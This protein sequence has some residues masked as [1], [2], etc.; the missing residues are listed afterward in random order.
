MLE[1][2]GKNADDM[3]EDIGH[4]SEARTKM[5]EYLVGTLKPDPN[6]VS[7]AKKA[8]KVAAEI[9]SGGGLNPFAIVILLIAIA[10]GYYFSQIHGK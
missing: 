8:K 4:S 2:A 5:K 9:K 10:A 1:F 7:R 3:F 6:S